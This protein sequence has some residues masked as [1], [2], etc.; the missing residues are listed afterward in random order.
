MTDSKEV[1]LVVKLPKELREA[2]VQACSAEDSNASREVRA[3][4]RDYV[5][6]HGQTQMKI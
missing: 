2:F 5:K 1:Q 3:F 6:R 4:V